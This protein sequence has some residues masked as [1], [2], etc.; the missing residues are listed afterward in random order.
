MPPEFVTCKNCGRD[1]I[2]YGSDRCPDCKAL[3]KGSPVAKRGGQER[4]T[5]KRAAKL[6]LDFGIGWDEAD[7]YVRLLAEKAVKGGQGDMRTFL[8]QMD[9]LKPSPR[10]GAQSE[11]PVTKVVITGETVEAAQSTM[12]ALKD[13]IV[14]AERMVEDEAIE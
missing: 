6:L 8:N 12:Q 1:K 7:E 5:E 4:P 2:P 13:Y 9:E 11:Q 10:A 14:E 3:V